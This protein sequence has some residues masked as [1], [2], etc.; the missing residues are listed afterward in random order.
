MK[1]IDG[2]EEFFTLDSQ[3]RKCQNK[4]SILECK[5]KEYLRTGRANCSCIPHYL[6]GFSIKVREGFNKEKEEVIYQK[7]SSK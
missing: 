4:Q 5:A 2:T 6:R 3:V 7:R 1:E